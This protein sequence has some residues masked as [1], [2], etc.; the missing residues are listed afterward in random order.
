M[1]KIQ[2]LGYERDN[3]NL[4]QGLTVEI[5]PAEILQI[6]GKNGSGKS[7]LL[8]ILAGFIEPLTGNRVGFERENIHYVGHQNGLKANLTVYENLLLINA[9]TMNNENIEKIAEK[10]GIKHLLHQYTHNLSAGQCR[11]LCLIRLLLDPRP[12]W[13][14]DEPMT[15]LD[16]SAQEWLMEVFKEHLQNKGIIVVATHQALSFKKSIKNIH[17][18]VDTL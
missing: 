17:L 6:R 3:I 15:A 2:N 5:H 7:T 11:K 4:F 8:R 13:I 14:L 18:G 12:I 1:L 10:T 9:L 16:D